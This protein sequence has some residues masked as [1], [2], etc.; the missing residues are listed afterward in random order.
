MIEQ[1][2]QRWREGVGGVR[3]GGDG[4]H[5]WSWVTPACHWG[6]GGSR[7]KEASPANALR[8]AAVGAVRYNA[9]PLMA[10]P[11]SPFIPPL[12]SSGGFKLSRKR[13]AAAHP[14]CFRRFSARGFFA[15][16]LELARQASAPFR[17][18]DPAERLVLA[19]GAAQR[20][21]MDLSISAAPAL[22]RALSEIHGSGLT[23]AQ[24][25]RLGA[26]DLATA[27]EAHQQLLSKRGLSDPSAVF[28][29]WPA[30]AAA[31][32][33]LTEA[34]DA[35]SIVA[36]SRF[37]GSAMDPGRA[38]L[39]GSARQALPAHGATSR[40]RRSA[41]SCSRRSTRCTR[42]WRARGPY[43]LAGPPVGLGRALRGRAPRTL[44]FDR[45]AQSGIRPPTRPVASQSGCDRCSAP[46][47]PSDAIAVTALR[48]ALPGPKHCPGAGGGG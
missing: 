29:G 2:Q 15:F 24:L 35:K 30:E 42:S 11:G 23:A 39:D 28:L 22:A 17:L 26:S 44:G 19:W 6:A 43:E 4:R 16:A 36:P 5:V 47:V 7:A 48:A 25:K 1:L 10:S 38:R 31:S 20:A 34:I 40:G 12:G 3:R 21:K 32:E 18:P 13:R 14:S 46:G 9:L 27:L 33:P 41:P 8:R 37:A 45:G